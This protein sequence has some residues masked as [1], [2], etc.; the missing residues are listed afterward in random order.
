MRAAFRLF[1]KDGGGTIDAS[2]VAG[3]LGHNVTESESVWQDIIHEVDVD[4]DG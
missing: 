4:G 3:I 2:E 1:D